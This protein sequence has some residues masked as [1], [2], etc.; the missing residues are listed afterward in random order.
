MAQLGMML[1]G[2]FSS[3]ATAQSHRLLWTGTWAV[4]PIRDNP[5]MRFEKQTLRQIVHTSV[6][7]RMARIHISNLFGSEPLTIEN[8][9]IARPRTGS[10]IVAATDRKVQFG[11]LTS[12]IVQPGTTAVSDPIEFQVPRLADV[13]I[14]FYFPKATTASTYH[15]TG[16]QTCY[17]ANGDVGGKTNISG[18]KTTQSYYFLINLDAQ[19]QALLGSLVTMGASITDGYASTT[20]ANRRWPN[21][22]AQRLVDAGLNIG[23]LNQGISGNRLLAA[24][25]GDS[26]ETRFDRDVLEQPAVHWVVF[27]DDP[28][29][30][31]GSTKPPPTG[32]QLIAAVRRLITR[33][34][35]KQ[36]KFICST[37][38]PYQGASYWT[39]AGE[40][41][42]E[43]I[44]AFIRDKSSGCNGVI[45]QDSAT[46]DPVHPTQYLSAYDSGDHLHPNTAGLQAIADAVDLQS[47]SE[48]RAYDATAIKRNRR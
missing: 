46:H 45:D 31:L 11:G 37:L 8:V 40:A 10:S 3:G 21:D 27:S 48:A 44:N 2:I 26:A 15:G 38:T 32:D 47:F 29:N 35:E 22:L 20:N 24:G 28:I 36:I 43:Q 25:A 30:D 23:V 5:G 7:G 42:R 34:H 18:V 13:A 9:H 16:F 33:A 14:S 6:G 1:F 4:S 17:I 41:A 12:V 19:D 39:P